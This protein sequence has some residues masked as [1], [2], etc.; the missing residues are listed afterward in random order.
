MPIAYQL[1]QAVFKATFSDVIAVDEAE[2]LLEWLR[3]H[4]GA[5]VDL[6]P[7]THLHPA[8]L[9]VL[10]AVRPWI[11]GWP[12]DVQLASWLESALRSP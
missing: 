8:N 11:V 2:A 10:M 5:S 6:A 4:P 1:E 7:C 3:S 9:Q 12:A